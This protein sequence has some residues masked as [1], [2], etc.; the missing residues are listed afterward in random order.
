MPPSKLLYFEGILQ[1][2]LKEFQKNSKHGKSVF[3]S[4]TE[5]RIYDTENSDWIFKERYQQSKK[6]KNGTWVFTW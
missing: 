1:E 6:K 4:V 2:N 5:S 3:L